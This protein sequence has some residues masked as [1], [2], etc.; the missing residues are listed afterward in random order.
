[1]PSLSL[2][3][4]VVEIYDWSAFA[5]PGLRRDILLFK[6]RS[7]RRMVSRGRVELPTKSL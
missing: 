1:M 5:L 2:R 4:A 6:L 7:K 3:A